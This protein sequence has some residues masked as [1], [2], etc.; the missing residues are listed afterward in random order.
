MTLPVLLHSGM[1]GAPQIK[2]VNGSVN[3]A[4]Y[5]LLCNGFNT[6]SV[7]SAT[8]SGGVATFNFATAPGFETLDT[9]MIEGASNAAVNGKWRTKSVGGNQ[10]LVDIPGLA[11]GALGGT[12]LMKFA[13]L[14]WERAFVSGNVAAY[15]MGGAAAHKRFIRIYDSNM[16]TTNNCYW[17]AYEN[18]T[19]ISSGTNPFPTTGEAA[20]NGAAGYITGD[21]TSATPWIIVGTPRAFY[22]AFDIY[23]SSYVGDVP[24]VFKAGTYAHC[25][26]LLFGELDK[27]QKVGDTYACYVSQ[28]G[29]GSSLWLGR[30]STG[31]N[32]SRPTAEIIGAGVTNAYSALNTWPDPVSGNIVLEGAPRVDQL[33]SGQRG[34]RG[35]MPGMLSNTARMLRDPPYATPNGTKFTGFPGVT[36]RLMAMVHGQMNDE[37]MI[38][39]DEDWGDE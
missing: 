1:Q 34:V 22:F 15:K 13:P 12:I 25:T 16:T 39:L 35:Y 30:A 3:A 37:Y 7:A 26:S 5:A 24:P 8:A 31:A 20:G 23:S 2:L 28:D 27:V 10:V 33:F 17:R 21:A 11:D 18:M 38:R 14:G 29:D 4:L 6:Q 36:G 32:N 9:V 19:G